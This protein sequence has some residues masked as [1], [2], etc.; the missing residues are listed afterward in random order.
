MGRG[1]SFVGGL[2]VGF[3]LAAYVFGTWFWWVLHR[4][5][6]M[7]VTS[8]VTVVVMLGCPGLMIVLGLVLAGRR[9]RFG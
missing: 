7:G 9:K 1:S 5:F 6:I 2:L 4:M 3:G 8:W